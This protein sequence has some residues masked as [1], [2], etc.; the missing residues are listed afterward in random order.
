MGET[1]R[2][3]LHLPVLSVTVGNTLSLADSETK[4]ANGTNHKHKV[5]Y[6]ITYKQKS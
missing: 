3:I 2:K 5:K 1:K 6:P 4:S